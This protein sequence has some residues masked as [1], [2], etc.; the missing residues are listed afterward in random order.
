MS[1]IDS[2]RVFT[3]VVNTRN[4]TSAGRRLG[5]TPSAVSKQIGMLEA[6]LGV[7][8]LNRTTRAVNPTEAGEIYAARCQRI[9]EELEEAEDLIADLDTAP[10][11]TLKVAAESIFGRAILARI[12]GE[13]QQIYPQVAVELYLTDHSLDLVKHGFDVGVHL[14]T[15]T[16]PA[17]D[18]VQF[19]NHSVVLCASPDYLERHP[20]PT[21]I[22][23]LEDHQLVKISS[24]EFRQARQLDDY[25][26]NLGIG[27]GFALT[28]NDTDMAYHAAMAGL[29]IA[30]LPNYLVTP[31]IERGR[32]LHV[33]PDIT[34][35][36]HPVQLVTAHSKQASRK[37]SA[38]VEF[39]SG[40]FT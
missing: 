2:L 33:L 28:V 6:R 4:F 35:D 25:F 11:G 37:T 21:S 5:L 8:L 32:L 9:L 12:V 3:E 20:T 7:R 24:M 16:D 26:Y 18:G 1:R 39:V 22:D 15:L 38:F 10:R 14:G 30:P 23:D 34:T 27:D 17:L 31:Q 36:T 29:G 13:F 19:A 40:Y